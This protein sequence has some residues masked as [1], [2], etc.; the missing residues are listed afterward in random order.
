MMDMHVK[1]ETARISPGTKSAIRTEYDDDG[2]A[3]EAGDGEDQ[4]RDEVSYPC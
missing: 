4:P 2:H 3:R 1:P